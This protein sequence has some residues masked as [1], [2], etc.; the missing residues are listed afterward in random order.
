MIMDVKLISSDIKEILR[1]LAYN[2][3]ALDEGIK[4]QV[5]DSITRVNE[6]SEAKYIY[7]VFEME[8]NS[9]PKELIFLK[10]DGIK[11]HLKGCHKVVLMAA[12]IG[13]NVER[14]IRREQIRNMSNAVIMDACASVLI[15]AVCDTVESNLRK[16]VAREGLFLTTR[17][18]PG[19]GDLPIEIQNQ[20]CDTLN[21]AKTIGLTV[22][23]SGILIPRKSVTAIMGISKSSVKKNKR[24]CNDCNLKENCRFRRNGVSCSE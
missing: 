19:Y 16:E 10:G 21:T 22:S 18:S 9:F 15:E 2:N 14:L 4:Q 8:E 17:F 3:Q 13:I 24:S 11:N 23:D 5:L 6:A 1:Y 12:T 7:K 20:F